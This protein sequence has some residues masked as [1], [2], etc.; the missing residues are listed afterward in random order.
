M[1]SPAE[2]LRKLLAQPGIL[3]MPGCHDALSARLAEE[4]GFQSAFR[5]AL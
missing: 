4:A 3:V 2:A 5:G 1:N